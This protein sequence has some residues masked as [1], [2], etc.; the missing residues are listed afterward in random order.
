M[1]YQPKGR[2]GEYGQALPSQLFYKIFKRNKTLSGK[3][4]RL[5]QS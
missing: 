2:K 1:G 3:K 5:A 4:I